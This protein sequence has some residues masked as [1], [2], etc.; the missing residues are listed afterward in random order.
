MYASLLTPQ[1]F[2]PPADIN[3]GKILHVDIIWQIVSFSE[4]F[5][6]E[7]AQLVIAY[8]RLAFYN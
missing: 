8:G 4:T 1:S 6:A 2:S 3:L 5:I 7:L